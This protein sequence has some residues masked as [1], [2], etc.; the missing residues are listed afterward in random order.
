MALMDAIVGGCIWAVGLGV[1]QMEEVCG[2]FAVL[3]CCGA[4]GW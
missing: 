1:V 2:G 4:G 3:V